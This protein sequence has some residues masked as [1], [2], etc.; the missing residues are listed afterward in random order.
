MG[1]FDHLIPKDKK[2][3]A[4]KAGAFDHLIPQKRTLV[5]DVTGFMANVNR[6]L[7]VGDEIAAGLA[8]AG[9]V[10]TGKVKPGGVGVTG[11]LR[12]LKAGFDENMAE[13]RAIEDDFAAR[14][15][16]TASLGKGFGMAASAAVPAA[17]IA[18]SSSIAMTAARA[19][20]QGAAMG[21]GYGMVDRGDLAERTDA[22]NVGAM[23][24]AVL[25]A[26][27]GGAGQAL[28]NRSV[29]RPERAV[30]QLARRSG[31][32]A[33]TM[34]TAADDI[35]A[36]GFE[37]PTITDVVDESGRGV[38]RAAAS[39]QTPARETARNF[40]EQRAMDL[41]DRM[42]QQ[43]R[44]HISDDPRSVVELEADVTRRLAAGA[45]E[46]FVSGEGGAAVSARL[47]SEFDAANQVVN[48][49]YDAARAAAPDAAFL[50]QA[51]RPQLAANLREAVRDFSPQ[52]VPR[53]TRV[54]TDIDNLGTTTL[55]DLYEGRARLG[56]L[57]ASNDPV[58]ARAAGQLVRALD[59]EIADAAERGVIAGDPEVVGLWRTAIA[60][61]RDLGRQYQGDDLIQ[62]LT[63]RGVHGDGRVNVVAPEDASNALLGRSGVSNRADTLRDLTR[64]RDR[65]GAD[66]AEWRGLQREAAGRLLNRDA[67]RETYGQAW[68]RFSRD[69]PELASLLMS[70]ADA[71]A[72]DAARRG[73]EEAGA[74]GA[75]LRLGRGFMGHNSQEFVPQAE[76]LTGDRR[77]MALAAARRD[78]ERRSGESVANAPGVA[79]RLSTAPEQRRRNAALLGDAAPAFEAGMAT[80]A[81]MVQ[82]AADISPRTGSQTQLRSQD[83]ENLAEGVRDVMAVSTGEPTAILGVVAN[84]LKTLGMS[85]RDAQALVEIATDPARLQEAIRYLEPRVGRME[86]IDIIRKLRLTNVVAVGGA[87]ARAPAVEVS[88]PGRPELGVGRAYG[89]SQRPMTAGY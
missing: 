69:N 34:R 18:A 32:T 46:E 7:G 62:T 72:L 26:G 76:A 56:N 75:A 71:A 12:G 52:D 51:E 25:G 28:A 87:S 55:R 21:Y 40:A 29:S 60:A 50:P 85:D 11:A 86:A 48:R 82:N 83:A 88:V 8:T 74:D 15:P 24:G 79:R 4:K 81:R 16:M 23:T 63:E 77:A 57:R 54:L 37:S 65:V 73:I 80:E 31:Q 13:Q 10:V 22:A 30:R 41:P 20:T 9:D 70:D 27:I 66:S 39:R 19:G 44:T 84:R 3:P 1:A 78:V 49:A 14:R 64:I 2:A 5:E 17:P 45:P 33:E 42:S 6:G 89:P 47:N 58:E 38:L 61:R 53:V 43:A 59:G 68:D 36:N 67:G 35:R